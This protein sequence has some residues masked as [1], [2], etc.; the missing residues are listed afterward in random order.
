MRKVLLVLFILTVIATFAFAEGQKEEAAAEDSNPLNLIKPGKLVVAVTQTYPPFGYI[1][2][3]GDHVGL[4]IDLD[5][6]ICKRLGLEYEPIRIEWSGLMPSLN[7]QKIDMISN[8][9]DIT[10]ERKKTVTFA[11]AWI[12][13]GGVLLVPADSDVY[14]LEDIAG[15]KI[16]VLL[17]SSWVPHAKR[18]NPGEIK[19]YESDVIGLRDVAN[20]QVD[21]CITDFL[22][23]TYAIKENSYPIRYVEE[24]VTVMQKAHV[25]KKG[26]YELVRAINKVLDEIYADGTYAEITEKYI[27]AVPWPSADERVMTIFD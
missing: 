14:E 19:Y 6:E 3:N 4:A 10:E 17:A 27:N 24:Y 23:G 16:G 2:K 22:A 15:K 1:D 25:F 18:L 12:K 13:S 26:N 11:N 5:R 20:R 9:M 7:A 8:P 21:A